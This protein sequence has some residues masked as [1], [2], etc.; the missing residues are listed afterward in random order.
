MTKIFNTL[1]ILFFIMTSVGN[2]Y[3]DPIITIFNKDHERIL[4]NVSTDV[5]IEESF[6]EANG[7]VKKLEEAVA[8]I[9]PAAGLAA[10]QIGI[11]KR[12]FL[13]TIDDGKTMEAVINPKIIEKSVQQRSTWEACFSAIQENGTSYAAFVKRHVHVVVEYYNI[14][15]NKVRK[16]LSNFA[17]NVFQHEVDHLDGIIISNNH[18]KV[19]SFPN[20]KEL[21]N[22]LKTQRK[23]RVYSKPIDLL[24]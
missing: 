20:A 16:I 7:I 22:K 17:A 2:L 21:G 19:M 8:M 11:N 23:S 24:V 3:A 1:G 18:N 10:P 15:G 12:V 4:T 6:S 9:G 5:D 14:D 13:Y